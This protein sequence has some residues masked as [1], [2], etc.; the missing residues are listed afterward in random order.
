M[1]WLSAFPHFS[2]WSLAEKVA[3]FFL[4]P[5]VPVKVLELPLIGSGLVTCPSLSQSLL[6]GDIYSHWARPE[7]C[8]ASGD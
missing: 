8:G 7:L 4:S 3:F 5:I 2:A 6:P 1:W